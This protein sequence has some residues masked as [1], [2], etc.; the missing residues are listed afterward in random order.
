MKKFTPLFLSLMLPLLLLL[1]ILMAVQPA[2][3]Q[4][5]PPILPDK[6]TLELAA[7]KMDEELLNQLRNGETDTA[8]H[9][10]IH[11]GQQ[12]DLNQSA[13]LARTDQ[14][15]RAALTYN[16]LRTFAH[17]SQASIRSY[18]DQAQTAGAV[19][20][21]RPFFIFNGLAVQA[22]PAA[23]WQIALRDDVESVTADHIYHLHD[24]Q[25]GS[26]TGFAAAEPAAP[27]GATAVEWNIAHINADDVWQQ[28][29]ITGAGILVA[30]MD[31]GVQHNHPALVNQ[32]AGSLGSGTFDHN[33]HWF[34][35]TEFAAPFPYDDN[36]HGSHTMGTILG[37][38]GLGPLTDDI[39]VAP[40]ARW[41]AVKIFDANGFAPASVIHAGFEWLLAP[42]P[43]GVTPGSPGCDPS[44]A[45]DVVNNS[46]GSD[47]AALTEFLPDV[48]A[49]RAAG[50]WP[51]FSAG[52]SGPGLGTIGSPASFAE[53]FATG[54]T[55][56]NDVIAGFSSQGPS[57]LTLNTKPDVVAPG[58]DIRSSVP[59][60]SYDSFNGTSMAGPHAVGLAALMLEAAPD[61][62]L[63]TMEQII[64]E[65]A[66]DL[67]DPGPDSVYGY[68]RIDAFKA[69]QR[70]VDSADL[71][72]TVRD[73]GTMA[74]LANAT[75]RVFNDELDV[76][77]TTDSS[78]QYEINY[79]IGGTYSVTVSLYGY[80][81]E[82]FTDV[83]LPS[84][85]ETTLDVELTALPTHT[86]SGHV[87]NAISP[88]VPITNAVI[89]ILDTP[90]PSVTTDE[91]GFY[92]IVVAEGTAVVEAAA[93]SFATAVTSTTI[94]ADTTIDFFL[95][96]LPPVLLVDD[97][98]GLSRSIAPNVQEYY[99]SALDSNGY[100]YTY[101]DIDV[102]GPPDFDTIRQYAAVVWFGGEFGRVKDF[103]EAT[104]AQALMDYLDLGGRLLYVSQNHTFYF[105]D[106]N[107]C[108]SPRLGGTGPCPFTRD[109]LGAQ[110]WVLDQKATVTFGVSGHPVGDG[111]GPIPMIYPPNFQ[112]FTDDVTGTLSAQLTFTS[113]DN[114]P[115]D[116]INRTAY[117]VLS[118]TA[119]FRTL[120]MATPLE[121]M[122]P[123]DAANVMFQVM[124]W[125]GISGLAEGVTL[126]P[127]T[128]SGMGPAGSTIS[129]TLSL[130][131]LSDFADSFD[132]AVAD[133]TWPTT[134][135]DASFSSEIMQIGPVPPGET[136]EFGITVAIPP[137]SQPGKG[138]ASTIEAVS[139]SG[140][141]Y[142]AVANLTALVEMVY[143][144][145][146][147]D[148]CGSGVH[149][150]WVDSL[151]GDRWLLDEGGGLPEYVSVSLPEP[152]V[153]FNKTYDHLWI[154]DHA[155]V[156]FADDNVYGDR[157][158]SGVPPI[159]NPTILDPNNAIYLAWGTSYWHPSDEDPAAGVYTY[160]DTGDG[161]NQFIITY[162]KYPNF[163][164]DGDDTMQAILDLDTYEITVQYQTVVY[165]NFAVVG[166][167]NAGGTEGILYVNDQVP[168]ENILHNEL[169]LRYTPGEI[170]DIVEVVLEPSSATGAAN[171][172]STVDY[173]L[174]LMNT[175]SLTDSFTLEASGHTW[176]VTFYDANFTTPIT[177]LD[178][179]PSCQSVPFGV[180]VELPPGTDLQQ[181]Q[182][183]VRARSQADTLVVGTAVLITNQYGNLYYFPIIQR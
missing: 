63:A 39:G 40:G 26:R 14:A 64:R 51:E 67:G 97:D 96:P 116:E 44:R 58:V 7:S 183:T 23:L 158:P 135:W 154:N 182:V 88:T 62:D 61:L 181:D 21:Y 113:T 71:V 36:A 121:A 127:A 125:F 52:N 103:S 38:D 8:V 66:V 115:L 6:A 171:G 50:I 25:P 153:F 65:T 118:D 120:F 151:A 42:C 150:N 13:A 107:V 176:P 101:W 165:S 72:G 93:F 68:G 79:L 130:R 119:D 16:T 166:I 3:T 80:E 34:D 157:I 87:F 10:I 162:Y 11:L 146:D 35:A 100:N 106:D 77:T 32:Y 145:H 111:L 132:L 92:Q 159:P 9:A 12:A 75:V 94:T 30:N 33:F 174:M 160:H 128:Q 19:V 70:L 89:T 141:P 149:F 180:R 47:N 5:L 169:A 105:G 147:S 76:T 123:G 91:N 46:W 55:D 59:G 90:L 131:N 172:S 18:L 161:R 117:S 126:A 37:G 84:N 57:P 54:A 133:A 81:V 155:T 22:T 109:Y 4:E 167:E 1:V 112:D 175:G 142:T 110:D 82:S 134:I 108:D 28:Y 129:F 102:D 137:G 170:P 179:V 140:T 143:T 138:A 122:P 156:L 29:G 173:V 104:Q 86:L 168:P 98:E 144:L 49:L 24:F 177:S 164:G 83:V 43:V 69:V 45:P 152:F 17:N 56:I 27:Q 178:D 85:T 139:Q 53:S 95:D 41:I 15:A 73:A 99:F 78:G 148:T 2:R 124:E 163:L 20:S 60:S 31:T 114:V 48:Q 136:A 74:P